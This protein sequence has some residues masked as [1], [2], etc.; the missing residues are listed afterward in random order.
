[1]G[2]E[3]KNNMKMTALKNKIRRCEE[4]TNDEKAFLMA[5][6]FAYEIFEMFYEDFN[7]NLEEEGDDGS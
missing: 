6:V 5:F 3:M 4:F 2:Y 1:M 7:K